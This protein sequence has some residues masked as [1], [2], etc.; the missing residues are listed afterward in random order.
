M[1]VQ[2]QLS[3]YFRYQHLATPPC[4]CEQYQ[5]STNMVDQ[6][7]DLI[8]DAFGVMQITSLDIKGGGDAGLHMKIQE[9]IIKP[10]ARDTG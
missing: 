2:A 8:F 7:H 1:S 9:K 3:N 4:N 10:I 5:L 6:P